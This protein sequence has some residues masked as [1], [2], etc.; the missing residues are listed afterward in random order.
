MIDSE[1]QYANTNV[2]IIEKSFDCW[3]D[4]FC[5]SF[6]LRIYP[7]RDI[8]QIYRFEVTLR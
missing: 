8:Q 2:M 5:I 4:I 1:G 6:V 3:K 7:T